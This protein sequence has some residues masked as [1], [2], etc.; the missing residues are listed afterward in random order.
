MVAFPAMTWIGCTT[1]TGGLPD[2]FL[3]RFPLQPHLDPYSETDMADLAWANADSLSMRIE[4]EAS[5]VFARACK[6]I[7]RIVNRYI[8]NSR[9]L[10]ATLIDTEVAVEVVTVLNSTTLD[11]LDADQA[12]MLRFLL[13]HCRREDSRGNIVY[14]SGVGGIATAIGK[15]RDSQAVAL[16]VEPHL[17]EC[18]F[19]TVTHGGRALT[20]AGV[21]RAEQL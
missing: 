17:I 16:Q 18:G 3:A 12:A 14:Q 7:P 4:P 21:Q 10:G 1:T 6:G 19:L 2:P 9:S 11:G 8:R 15:S 5:W 13:R 20:A